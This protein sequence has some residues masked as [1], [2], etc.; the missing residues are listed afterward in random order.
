MHSRGLYLQ[1]EDESM[2]E[3]LMV[4]I[5]G[6]ENKTEPVSPSDDLVR[7]LEYDYS[8]YRS[9]IRKLRDKHPLL[10]ESLDGSSLDYEDFLTVAFTLPELI[11][12]FDL[13]G[14]FVVVSRLA[15]VLR[16]PDDNSASFLLNNAQRILRALEEPLLT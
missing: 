7:V 14:Y 16:I 9:G 5:G 2:V 8:K 13:V 15:S 12:E 3:I 4:D 1:T 11:K 6:R 10:E